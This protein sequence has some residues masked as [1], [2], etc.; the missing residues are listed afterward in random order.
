MG[1]RE[2]IY[3]A[4][5]CWVGATKI[6]LNIYFDHKETKVEVAM[7]WLIMTAMMVI[8]IVMGL[9]ARSAQ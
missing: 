7:A 5:A 1:T 9:Q 8:V 4:N 2:L 6:L 3:I